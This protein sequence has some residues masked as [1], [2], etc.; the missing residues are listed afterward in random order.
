MPVVSVN[1][2]RQQYLQFF[3][4]RGHTS[5]ASA[6]L[7][8]EHDPT[9][10]FTGSGM[11]PLLPYLLGE[12]HPQ[13][14]RLVNAQKSFRAE[15]IEEVGDN[16]H[17]TFFEMLGNWSLGD[18]FKAEQLPWIFEFLTQR[19][20]L[21][22]S[23]LYITVFA[24]DEAHGLPRDTTSTELWQSIFAQAGIPATTVELG[25]VEQGSAQGMQAGRIFYY[26]AKKN[27]WSRSGPP[28]NM[29]VGEPGGPD[30]EIFF[31]FGTPHD[32]AFGTHCHPNCDCGRF[33][34][35]GNSVFM[36]YQQTTDGF[37]PLP[38]KNVDFG[39]G[40]ERIAAAAN[41]Q[42]DVFAIDVFQHI[43][44]GIKE[45]YGHDY[46]AADGTLKHALRIIADHLRAAVFLI[47]DG[48]EPSNKERGYIVRRLLRR[49]IFQSYQRAPEFSSISPL[50]ARVT[51]YYRESYPHLAS[52]SQQIAD[53]IEAE[54]M[55]FLRTLKQGSKRLQDLLQQGSINGHDAFDLY[56]TYG[57]PFELTQ[58]QATARQITVDV[59]GFQAELA[60][61]RQRSRQGAEQKFKGGLADHSEQSIK[62][63]TATHLLHQALRTVLGEHVVQK[64][65][66]ITPERL[67]FDFT[68]PTK[69]STTE[70]QA[71]ETLVNQQIA[72]DLPVNRV[73]M[74]VAEA[75]SQGALGLF[76]ERYG[77]RVS[78][79]SIGD[80]SREICGGPHVARTS[81]L[82][83]FKITKEEAVSAGIR[84]LK[85]VL[86]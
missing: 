22:P 14:N 61:H 58:E 9:T 26:G 67:R 19:V 69:L 7:V 84:R 59:T 52:R 48:V 85:A 73:E 35:I 72:A 76:G 77:E 33:M 44:A 31:D 55:K 29:P 10:L 39:G 75:R 28:E 17:T 64:G 68:H 2:L 25:T 37:A 42:S 83:T 57:F 16:R 45:T 49:A 56:A 8:P 34:E 21:D 65:S 63:H 81:T 53:A 78:V 47:G 70:R 24:G 12:P 18:Y 38:A 60:E 62:Y 27:W 43:F 71:V 50:V 6:P 66:N 36:E 4:E 32:P 5:I 13:G 82:G 11:Q 20:G 74:T 54:E 86:E 46:A 41:N 23:R 30:S 1:T 3:T 80:F 40:L 15:D 51:D 79:Y